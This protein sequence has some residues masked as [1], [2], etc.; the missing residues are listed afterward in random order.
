[1]SSLCLAVLAC[2]S[3]EFVAASRRYRDRTVVWFDG[4]LDCASEGLARVEVEIALD[5]GGAEIVL[6]LRGLTFLDA[7]GV[8]VLIDARA[9]CQAQQRRLLLVPAPDRVQRI[10]ELCRVDGYFEFLAPGEHP[11]RLVA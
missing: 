10:F 1:L 9:A 3:S 6:D 4:E 11:A 7:R 2:P 5:R 8:H